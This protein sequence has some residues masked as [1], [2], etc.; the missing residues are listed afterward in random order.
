MNQQAVET[1]FHCLTEMGKQNSNPVLQVINNEKRIVV[2]RKYPKG[3]LQFKGAGWQAFYHCHANKPELLKLFEAEHGH[4]HIFVKVASEPVSW[5]HM[6]ALSM[7]VLG[8]PLRWFTVNHWVTDEA[9]VKAEVLIQ[10]LQDIPFAHQ[11]TL[12]TQWLLAMLAVYQQELSA[13]LL[14]RDE[15]FKG[16]QQQTIT[17][18]RGIYLLTE[19]AV[20]LKDKLN[21]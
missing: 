18:D 21:K 17:E 8:Q 15:F 16:K 3:M 20:N 2:E 9:W 12:L 10:K 19:Q 7:D 11:Q 14:R 5:S 4:F 1:L 13:L 6:V